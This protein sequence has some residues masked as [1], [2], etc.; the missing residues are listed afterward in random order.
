MLTGRSPGAAGALIRDALDLQ[1]RHPRLWA[2]LASGRARVWKARKV[3]AWMHAAELTLEQARFVDEATTGYVETLA[4]AAFERLAQVTI[5]EADPASA[6]ARRL[7]ASLRRF[8]ATGRC[9]EHGLRTLVVRCHAGDVVHLVATIDRIAHILRI[10]GDPGSVDQRRSTALGILADPVR[11]L[12]L[13]ARHSVPDDPESPPDD[14]VDRDVPSQRELPCLPCRHRPHGPPGR[15]D[16][17]VA[18]HAGRAAAR[19][20]RLVIADG[21]APSPFG[22]GRLGSPT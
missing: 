14:P 1:H 9:S 5:V 8:V 17:R 16:R 3:A 2:A 4:W 20:P 15:L 19:R 21:C 6:E 11:A 18:A 12:T 13:L 22:G 10:E 7:A